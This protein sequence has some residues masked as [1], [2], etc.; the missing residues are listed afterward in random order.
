MTMNVPMEFV[1]LF[2]LFF[3]IL[4]NF[5]LK[6]ANF[7]KKNFRLKKESCFTR[8]EVVGTWSREYQFFFLFLLSLLFSQFFSGRFNFIVFFIYFCC[9]TKFL[10][11]FDNIDNFFDFFYAG[12]QLWQQILWNK[13]NIRCAYFTPNCTWSP[14][15]S[16]LV[17]N[18]D[19]AQLTIR[20]Q[21]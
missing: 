14:N 5:C 10:T 11:I 9:V 12:S 7:K 19:L 4:T 3:L 20:L 6:K 13:F 17:R 1:F 2:S 16:V 15:Y 21:K 18:L 8:C